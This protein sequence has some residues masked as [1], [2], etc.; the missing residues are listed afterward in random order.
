MCRCGCS[1]INSGSF[2]STGYEIN[3]RI[4]IVMRLLG[5]AQEG[6]NLF[7]NLM[8]ICDGLSQQAYDNVVVHIHSATKAVF[9]FCC[10]KAVNEEKKENEKHERRLLDLKISGDRSWKRRGFK[11]LY[12]VT[13]LI[14]YNT[15]KVIDLIVK[16]SYC[17]ECNMW[18][19][20]QN[21]DKYNEWLEEHEENR[22]KNHEGSAGKMEMSLL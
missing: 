18:K 17:Q 1:T 9:D 20:R 14:A 22:S 6:I 5:I 19:N 10:E 12:D 8:D 15:G 7:A 16:S 4:V 2:I 3:R 21:T 11:F 13:T